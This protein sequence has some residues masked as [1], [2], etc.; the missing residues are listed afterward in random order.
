MIWCKKKVYGFRMYCVFEKD[1]TNC[2][3]LHFLSQVKSQCEIIL[4]I[5]FV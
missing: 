5:S 4:V 1:M 3:Y 2:K